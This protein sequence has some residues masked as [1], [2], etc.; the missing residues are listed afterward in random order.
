ME[1]KNNSYDFS[2]P[3]RQSIYA[4][5]IIIVKTYRVLIG[6]LWPVLV[7]FLINRSSS[8]NY[9]FLYVM[10]GLGTLGM[11]ISILNFFRYFFSI[12]GGELIIEKGVF[13][14]KKVSIPLERI[15]TINF[16]QN[17]IHR[18]AQ[19]VR[20]KVDTAG[21]AKEE[22]SFDALPIDMA[23]AFRDEILLAKN[24]LAV[25]VPATEEA[26]LPAEPTPAYQTILTLH[27]KNL[28][29]AGIT[30]NHIRSSGLLLLFFLWIFDKLNELGFDP[31][32]YVDRIPILEYSFVLFLFVLLL[33]FVVS[34]IIS[35]V[36]TAIGHYNLTFSRSERG[37][38]VESGLLTRKVVSALDHKIQT[39]SWYDNLLK[40][41]FGLYDF[42]MSQASS[43]QVHVKKAIQIPAM[44]QEEI[45]F[46]KKSLYPYAKKLPKT[47][48]SM[49]KYRLYRRLAFITLGLLVL[50]AGLYFTSIYAIYAWTLLA[51]YLPI[52]EYLTH[53]KYKFGYTKNLI[54]IHHGAVGDK[55]SIMPIHKVQ[56]I[57]IKQ[58]PYQRKHDLASL[59]I[60]H[61]AGFQTV[62]YIAYDDAIFVMDQL[63]G[64]AEASTR[65]WM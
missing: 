14:K 9:V 30:A 29:L 50:L 52:Q 27:P 61:A 31:V 36:R 51:L 44:T 39:I 17:I 49:S 35:M 22:V 7:L 63:M 43:E 10:I 64:R 28:L 37:F 38:V 24:R 19:I 6:Q 33:V 8:Q 18:L 5:L 15:Q 13:G 16:E 23:E 21:S 11:I 3:H 48:L 62:P 54:F 53:R 32:E 47:Y 20:V 65:P 34:F 46:V 40:R 42:T 55:T 58:S 1:K 45:D 2:V 57:N 56:S 41:F 60:Y 26:E 25:N 4:I 12:R 59:V